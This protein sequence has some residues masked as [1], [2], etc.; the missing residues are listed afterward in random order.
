[1]NI[2]SFEYIR[3]RF[4][5]FKYKEKYIKFFSHF[6]Q[7]TMDFLRRIHS[8]LQADL[9]LKLDHIPSRNLGNL[10]VLLDNMLPLLDGISSLLCH[11]CALPTVEQCFGNEKLSKINSIEAESYVLKLNEARNIIETKDSLDEA[12]THATINFLMSW[13][14]PAQREEG[15]GPKWCKVGLFVDNGF[16]E[17]IC[18]SIRQVKS[19]IL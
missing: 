1:M 7:Q 15:I 3:I 10:R 11:A 4:F 8:L 9:M 13:L 17:Q 19:V 14:A 5:L 2:K 16:S 12:M 6:D 18:A